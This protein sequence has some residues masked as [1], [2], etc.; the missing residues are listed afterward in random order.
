M[1]HVPR[2]IGRPARVAV[3]SAS[4]CTASERTWAA[5]TWPA[6]AASA[7][8][9][10][11]AAA[12]VAGVAAKG[13][14]CGSTDTGSVFLKCRRPGGSLARFRTYGGPLPA[15]YG[16]GLYGLGLNP[17]A[18]SRSGMRRLC[19]LAQPQRPYPTYA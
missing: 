16:L 2:P 15:G 9:T 18:L 19:G 5:A 3:Y 12:K 11:T 4:R 8:M 1:A 7:A 17:Q 10:Q 14:R 6:S 13:N